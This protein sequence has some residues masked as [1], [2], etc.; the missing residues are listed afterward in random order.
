M[1]KRPFAFHRTSIAIKKLLGGRPSVFSSQKTVRAPYRLGEQ[2]KRQPKD[3]TIKLR[4]NVA[5]ERIQAGFQVEGSRFEWYAALTGRCGFTVENRSYIPPEIPP[6]PIGAEDLPE[7]VSIPMN[8]LEFGISIAEAKIRSNLIK[9]YFKKLEVDLNKYN[10]TKILFVDDL[11]SYQRNLWE[12][13][14][15]LADFGYAGKLWS[16]NVFNSLLR[17]DESGDTYVT[18]KL[19]RKY[20]LSWLR[21]IE[22]SI[23]ARKNPEIIIHFEKTYSYDMKKEQTADLQMHHFLKNFLGGKFWIG[24]SGYSMRGFLFSPEGDVYE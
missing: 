8:W 23:D 9:E 15:S 2:M 21:T 22:R 14:P 10:K 24:A 1:H 11:Y 19:K 4:F 7:G 13:Y 18:L 12:K 3:A 5:L 17:L 16:A 20:F 6:F